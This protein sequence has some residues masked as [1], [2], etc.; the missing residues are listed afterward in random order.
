M[1]GSIQT[2]AWCSFEMVG[3]QL[4]LRVHIIDTGDTSRYRVLLVSRSKYCYAIDSQL[5][6][7]V[8]FLLSLA[9]MLVYFLVC[10][11]ALL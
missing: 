4:P 5:S 8:I 11:F 3:S 2:W 7:R 10:L 9:F 1:L 6:N